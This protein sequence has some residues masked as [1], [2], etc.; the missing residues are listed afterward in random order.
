MTS[1]T[2]H[3]PSVAAPTTAHPTIA[4]GSLTYQAPARPARRTVETPSSVESADVTQPGARADEATVTS[5]PTPTPSLPRVSRLPGPRPL[6]RALLLS[7]AA[8][9][10]GLVVGGITSFGQLLPGTLNWLAN[11]V[12]GWSIPMVLLVAWARGG[13]LRSAI[14]GGLVFVAMSQG[15]ALVSTLRGYPDQGIRW[16]LIGLV[17]GPVLGAAT[18]LLRHESRRIVAIA[19]GVLGGVILGDAVHGFVATPAGWGSWVIVASGA[20]AFL[21][22][23]AVVLLRA[24]RPTL[25]LAATA[26]LVASAY[27]LLLDPLLGLV[28]R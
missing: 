13:V 27:A 10:G 26:A 17:A 2:P 7:A 16:A 1:P 12:A 20:L 28:F 5:T 4:R 8:I 24:W 9:A 3:V 15:Y 14:T 25:L 19:A 18:A 23:T 21:V 11:S 6:S 22:V